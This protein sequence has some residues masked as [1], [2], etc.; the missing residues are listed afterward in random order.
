[1]QGGKSGVRVLVSPD[2]CIHQKSNANFSFATPI[3]PPRSPKMS[4]AGPLAGR[5]AEG[6]PSGYTR[7]PP[8]TSKTGWFSGGWLF[9]VTAASGMG[10]K[11]DYCCS[12][13]LSV[14]VLLS[15]CRRACHV[16][17]DRAVCFEVRC[18]CCDVCVLQGFFE[19]N[20]LI[21]L[22]FRKT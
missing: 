14:G 9:V 2:E 11:S 6:R 22:A 7:M 21:A 19:Q 5:P 16:Y 20:A 4:P 15:A 17:H 12:Y 1:M 18:V 13:R 10:R 8:S 3:F